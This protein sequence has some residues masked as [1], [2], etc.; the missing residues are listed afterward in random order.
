MIEIEIGVSIRLKD[1]GLCQQLFKRTEG[2]LERLLHDQGLNLAYTFKWDRVG[3]LHTLMLITSG[4]VLV[5]EVR[6]DL[7]RALLEA[8]LMIASLQSR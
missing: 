4:E 7:M 1:D 3:G 5:D 2:V 6:Q 8:S